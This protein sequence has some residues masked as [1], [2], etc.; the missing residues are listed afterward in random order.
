MHA[1]RTLEKNG[2]AK[3]EVKK[4]IFFAYAAPV[5]TEEEAKNIIRFLRNEQD[6]DHNVFAYVLNSEKLNS[7]KY[8]DDGEPAGSSG[9]VLHRV[10]EMK[11][12]S[13]VIVVVKRYYGGVKL[14]FGGLARAYRETASQAI[15]N[16]GIIDVREKKR[17]HLEF[18]YNDIENVKWLVSGFGTILKTE[19][20]DTI[21]FDVEIDSE[22]ETV[23]K[24][25]LIE[26]TSNRI[27]I[28]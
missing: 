17:M 8:D 1:Y 13:N 21:S 16:A 3:K 7:F 12:L 27:T 18:G 14:G 22:L 6:A 10:L 5:L 9:K 28:K 4:S 25:K 2:L 24:E 20:S 11:E 26:A 19:Y 15:E 23:F